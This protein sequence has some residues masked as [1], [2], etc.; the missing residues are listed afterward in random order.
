MP[1]HSFAPLLESVR[2]VNLAP[3][4]HLPAPLTPLLGRE[5][6]LVQ[7]TGLLRRPEIRLLTLTG[8]GGVGKTRLLLAV[9]HN[10][11]HGFADEV[12]FVPLAAVSD[13]NFVLP[14]IAQILGLGERSVGSLL[15]E[16]QEAVGSRS[17]LL[18]LDNF[19]HV[20]AAASSL[21]DLLTACP[22]LYLLVTSRAALRIYG[23]QEFA[24][25]PLPLPDLKGRP[26]HDTLSQYAALI[27]FVQRAQAITPDFQMTHENI[28]SIAEI[29]IRLDGLPLAIELAA[30]RTRL[31]SPRA[32]LA[33]LE[34]RLEVLTDGAHNLPARQQTLRATIAWSYH[35]L[36]PQQQLLFRYLAI[37]AGGCTLQA[38]E[39]L[40]QAAGLV[41][42]TVL[43]GVCTLLENHLLSQV[44]QVTGEPRLFMLET[45]REYGLECLH[46]SGDLADARQVYTRYFLTLAKEAE[47]G[48]SG[49][50][51]VQWFDRLDQE[52][53]NLRAVLQR[54]MTGKDNGIEDALRLGTALALFW[55]V[56]GHVSDGQ[57]WLEWVQAQRQGGAAVL[58][59]ALNQAARLAI[60]R[61]DYALAQTL[62][63]E[64]LAI[65]READDVQGMAAALFWLA[66]ATQNRGGYARARTLYQEAGMLYQQVGDQSGYASALAAM[67]YGAA[68]Q[69]MFSRAR[70]FAEEALSLCEKRGDKQGMLYALVRLIRCL[71][72]S[73]TDV[74][75]ARFLAQ[76]C[77]ELSREVGY[78]Q[79]I[80]A[81]LSY[82]GLLALEREEEDEARSCLEEAFRLRQGLLSPCGITR[83]R[84]YLAG[85]SRVQRD[86]TTA[87]TLYE[88]CLKE[89]REVGDGE[90]I[91][92]CLEELAEVVIAQGVEEE[93]TSECLWAGH[94][95]GAAEFL[96]ESIEAPLPP[97]H[98]LA[99]EQTLALA[100]RQVEEQAWCAAWT[101]GR[102]MTPEQALAARPAAT[103]IVIAAEEQQPLCPVGSFGAAASLRETGTPMHLGPCVSLAY[104]RETAL[105]TLQA[106]GRAG[107]AQDQLAPHERADKGA[108]PMPQLSKRQPSFPAPSGLTRRELDVLRLLADGLSNTQIAERLIISP[109]TVDGHLVSIYSKFH[110]SSRTAA[111]CYAHEN[112][113]L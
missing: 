79:G 88:T 98:R 72:L 24:L 91:A 21:V 52:Q 54:A 48:L 60:W 113:L 2:E 87:R 35:L 12:Y 80:A 31:L 40:A 14:A 65:Y 68:S 30:T 50:E 92:S 58:A 57:R 18:L 4:H 44:E 105:I 55:Y 71:Y 84:Y 19:E 81:A 73:Q 97:I 36:S 42:C 3:T 110:V 38:A 13:P 23:E 53:E 33:R 75:R 89:L 62:S 94:L 39:A 22:H 46:T 43:D 5:Q 11:L 106:E 70:V 56:R 64:S 59:Q 99:Y 82:L 8:P 7:L 74:A 108:V 15:Q 86:Y 49:P 102:A 85:L 28:R 6:E 101:R 104:E 76:R 112:H 100:H 34:R 27:L 67:A 10:L 93:I 95:W 90:F 32:L 111:V 107:P 83:G 61:D 77:L 16:V 26:S 63:S 66:D 25:S 17:V 45:I 96:R 1:N 20:L 51:Q 69:G 29:C 37:F 9:A 78:K 109:R 103:F 47:A 41:A